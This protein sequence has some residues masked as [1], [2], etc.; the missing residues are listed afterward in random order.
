MDRRIVELYDEYTHKPLARRVFMRRLAALTG[1]TAA[2]FAVLPMLE[3]NYAQAAIVDPG[4][5]RVTAG[6]INYPGAS[7]G[8]RA[9]LATPAAGPAKRAGVIVIHENRGLNPH[10]EDVARRLAVEGFTAMAP[11][12]LTPLGGTPPDEDTARSLIARVDRVVAVR[13]LV[14]AVPYLK[15]RPDSN[16]KVGAVGFCW[17]GGMTN[18]L[19]ANAPDLA[20]AAPFYGPVPS[21]EDA[22]KIKASLMLHYAGNDARINAGVPSYEAALKAAGVRYEVNMYDGVEH[23]FH[24][25]TNAGRYNKAAAELAWSRTVA[26][27][28]KN[29]AG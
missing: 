3:N 1:S 7:G 2:A 13:D 14:A 28:K 23:A 26:F 29:L 22:A 19:A 21:A 25:D 27:L 6:M 9:Y 16:G 12:L 18:Q 8:L 11:D 20:A 24:N 5:S 17:G 15:G 4:D 10:I